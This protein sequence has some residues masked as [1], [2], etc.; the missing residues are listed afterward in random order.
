MGSEAREL[1]EGMP[2]AFLP[3]KAGAAK[4]LIAL[5]LNGDGGGQWVV[6]VVDGECDVREGTAEKPDVTVSM[7]AGDF[8]DLIR[9]KLNAVQA[10]MT[11]RIKVSGNV[12]AVMQMMNWF[13][14]G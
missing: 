3:E 13:E 9:G 2:S 12:G 5:D 7:E 11:G 10:F 8:V 6:D 14:L 4:A 1:I